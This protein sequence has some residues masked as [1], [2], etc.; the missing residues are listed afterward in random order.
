VSDAGATLEEVVA[1]L[2]ACRVCR[3]RPRYG[4]PLPHEPR[5]VIQISRTARLCIASQAPGTRVHASGRPFTDPSGVRLRHWLGMDEGEFYDER[6]VAII[7]MGSCFPGL[8][9]KG[10]DLPPRRECAEIWRASLF[11]RLPA[12]ELV[13]AVGQYAQ[14]W[15]LGAGAK[16]GL[17]QTVQRWRTILSGP[18]RPRILPMPHPSWRNSGWLKRHPWFEAELV[19]V[20]RAEVRRLM[21]EASRTESRR[22]EGAEKTPMTS[23][24]TSIV[25]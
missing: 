18:A 23:T 2:R 10:G 25:P 12:L 14:A 16:A 11:H 7:P 6:A 8:D 20:L 17:T 24:T 13:L 4:G 9:A 5:P 22:V 19:P 21:T 15:H 3:D 1:A